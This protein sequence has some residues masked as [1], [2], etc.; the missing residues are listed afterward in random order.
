MGDEEAYA[1]LAGEYN[2]RCVPPWDLSDKSEEREFRRKID[3]ARRHPT[4]KFP[5]GWI[6]DDPAYAPSTCS[7]DAEAL[8]ASLKQA[9]TVAEVIEYRQRDDPEF[10]FLCKPTGLAGEICSWINE[11][12]TRPQPFLSVACTLAFLGALF[13]R[14][15]RDE[16]GSRTNIYCMGVA[17][18]SAGKAHAM[19]QIRRLSN[20]SGAIKFLGGDDV[21][22][23]A[24]IESR[25]SREPSTL[26]LW[27]EIGHMLVSIKGSRDQHYCKVVA[28]LMKLYSA[29]GS[30][31][32]GKEYTNQEDQR[33]IEEPCCCVYGTSTPERFVDG[34]SPEELQDG[35]LSRC[36]VFSST[37]VPPKRRGNATHEGPVPESLI[38]KV[39]G[40]V[41]WKLS[42]TT[43]GHS[44]GMFVTPL[45]GKTPPRQIVVPTDSQAE[46][47]FISFDEE[48]EKVGRRSPE[49]A[50]L[51]AKGEENARRIALI[52]AVGECQANPVIRVHVADYA[53]RLVRYLLTHFC[54]NIAQNIVSSQTERDKGKLLA[55]IRQ[56]GTNGCHK[57]GITR[58]TQWLDKTRRDAML[59]DMIEAEIITC[60]MDGKTVRYYALD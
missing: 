55:I 2:P 24:A 45:Y 56:S 37:E 3:E 21:T 22:S 49:F 7:I 18:S 51:W 27:D 23:D 35:W 33:R 29:A 17:P 50:C 46:R 30:V 40:W 12:S 11:T 16:S 57:R 44:V 31:Y 14:K 20:V 52:V 19:K 60:L 32:L 13:G 34:I 58:Q 28:M 54:R 42:Q 48:T 41:E 53:C 15:V 1:F 43:D 36:L 25:M 10:D 39:H 47:I 4:N 26:F 38:E 6:L 5:Y 59:A 9:E 8:L